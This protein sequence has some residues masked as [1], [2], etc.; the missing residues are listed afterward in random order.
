[1]PM[2]F[3]IIGFGARERRIQALVYFFIYTL[4]GS[5]FL[6]VAIFIIYFET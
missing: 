2:F 4:L 3:I 6:F 1:M 5:V